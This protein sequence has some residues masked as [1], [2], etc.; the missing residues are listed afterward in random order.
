MGSRSARVLRKTVN[1][2]VFL[3]WLSTPSVDCRSIWRL[4][5]CGVQSDKNVTA[6]AVNN[7]R[8]VTQTNPSVVLPRRTGTSPRDQK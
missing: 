1:F 5:N 2:S 4:G 8:A 3:S 6:L 7:D